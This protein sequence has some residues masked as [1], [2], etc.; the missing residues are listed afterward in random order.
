MIIFFTDI[1][2]DFVEQN[3]NNNEQT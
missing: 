2:I 1:H 3:Q